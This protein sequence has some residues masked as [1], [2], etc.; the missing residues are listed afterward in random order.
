M[1]LWVVVAHMLSWCGW[2]GL[3][4][5]WP[6]DRL[7]P[8]FIYSQPA[9]EAFIILSGFAI[10]SLLTKRPSYRAFILGRVF[11]LYPV[12]LVCLAVTIMATFVTPGVLARLSWRESGYVH[13]LEEIS[14][15]ERENLSAHV[16]AHLTL[17]HGTL[18]QSIL[19][20]S[21]TAILPP[22]WSLSLE[23]QY[24]L[25]APL[26]AGLVRRG[27]GWLGLGIVSW[28]GVRI[29][30]DWQS[31]TP[32]FLP[33]HLPLFLLGIGSHWAYSAAC[34]GG[35]ADLDFSVPS[36][37]IVVVAF[38]TSWH[39][40]TLVIWA[41]ACGSVAASGRDPYSRL[42]RVV[43]RTLVSRPVQW[44]GSISYPLFL[45]HWPAITFGLWSALALRPNLTS[46][47]AAAV[48]LGV[49]L[50][51][52]LIVAAVL[53]RFI[54]LPGIEAGRRVPTKTQ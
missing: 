17:L 53:H 1:S 36:A 30:A 33:V 48:L 51:L 6:L 52:T 15:Y 3:K 2:V 21:T 45:V 8:E 4:F 44:L 32:A 25:V 29:A 46:R 47:D 34:R 49:V 37:V 20:G 12:Y 54:E 9:V 18:P 10:S 35:K 50:P 28:V 42:L 19:P 23:W 14:R 11:R 16:I 22:A 27:W 43:S 5:P 24:Y 26:V 40:Y 41:L 38:V 39:T 31:L 13:L 7:W